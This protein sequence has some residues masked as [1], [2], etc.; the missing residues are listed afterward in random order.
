MFNSSDRNIFWYYD[1]ER[2]NACDPLA[3]YRSLQTFGD[4]D[5]G[6]QLQLVAVAQDKPEGM[7]A[8]LYVVNAVRHA[9]NVKPF[10]VGLDE[11]EHGLTDGEC[12]Q[13]LM[14][15]G[16]WIDEVKKKVES[17]PTLPKPTEAASSDT[18]IIK[19]MSASI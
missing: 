11:T 4:K 13:L 16:E 3:A 17:M 1:G 19:P 8:F 6:N 2:D 14:M 7:E 18:S 5:L 12:Y 10:S 9:F 15:F